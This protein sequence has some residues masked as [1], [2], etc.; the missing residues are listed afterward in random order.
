MS[1][2]SGPAL[3]FHGDGG[4]S[5]GGLFSFTNT[6][7]GTI[8]GG[9]NVATS[10][11]VGV[12]LTNSGSMSGGVSGPALSFRGDGGG[13]GGGIFSFT[14]TSTGTITGGTTVATSGT[15]GV[16]FTNSGS[17]SQSTGPALSFH[18]D[19]GGSGGGI[20]S[21]IN[22]ST[23]TITG[24]TTVSTS[25]SM[26]VVFTNSGSMS[27]NPAG[28]VL[29]FHGDGT[30]LDSRIAF[31]NAATGFVE[32]D[33]SFDVRGGM[34]LIFENDGTMTGAGAS[35][36]VLSV[37]DS[38]QLQAA[39]LG[40]IAGIWVITAGT[41]DD[42]VFQGTSGSVGQ[43]HFTGGGGSN[44]LLNQGSVAGIVFDATQSTQQT[45]NLLQNSHAAVT[46]NPGATPVI[47][48]LGGAGANA[49]IN[50][51]QGT[52]FVLNMIGGTGPDN[53]YN[54]ATSLPSIHFASGGSP[55]RGVWTFPLG[56]VLENVGSGIGSIQYTAPHDSSPDLL[57]NSGDDVGEITMEAGFGYNLLQNEGSRA[58]N[59]G[60]QGLIPTAGTTIDPVA[61]LTPNLP[62]YGD[63]PSQANVLV[64]NGS[65]V[66]GITLIG[67]HGDTSFY[68]AGARVQNVSVAAGDASTTFF[69]APAGINL[70]GVQF[71]GSASSEMFRNDARGLSAF[72]LDMGGGG[73]V[74]EMR[75]DSIGSPSALSTIALGDGGGIFSST[76]KNLTNIAVSGGRGAN[77]YE[78]RGAVATNVT[79]TGN[80][81]SD[82][83][84]MASDGAT[85]ISFSGSG[86]V[87]AANFANAIHDLIVTAGAGDASV[88]NYGE[89]AES[90]TLVGGTGNARLESL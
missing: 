2:S 5:G 36:T 43:I 24:G 1:G 34:N 80:T 32:G 46:P 53:L 59:I 57:L 67:G 60:L 39:N 87:T 72:T 18:G 35:G 9:T 64:N 63:L 28:P 25:G 44:T 23:G 71:V 76:G 85:G 84:L 90:V 52:G 68:N 11:G 86:I 20:F 37:A 69:N 31:Y 6:S 77:R 3:G 49:L 48:M 30:G 14:N 51:E 40:L 38:G 79:I 58:N 27:G 73:D 8:T 88:Y 70:S 4:G 55:D 61:V 26:G 45:L 83:L 7:T 54:A 15:M 56:D 12:I 81:G 21:F 74:V 10:G 22:T 47:E 62:N 16:I 19:G 75:G 65:S 82:L 33:V 50:F 13:S 66:N 29:S 89:S 17:M 41:N 78:L 42:F